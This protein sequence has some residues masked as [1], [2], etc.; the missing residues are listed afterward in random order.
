MPILT[1]AGRSLLVVALQ[2]GGLLLAQA[3]STYKPGPPLRLDF[4]GKHRIV[5]RTPAP[6]ADYKAGPAL[7]IDFEGQ[8]RVVNRTTAP[9]PDYKPGPALR[10]DFEGRHRLK[11]PTK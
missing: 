8:H 2:S 9:P 11:Q 1:L 4:E 3:N 7:R 10:I 6:P 5:T